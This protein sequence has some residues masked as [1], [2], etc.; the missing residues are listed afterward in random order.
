VDVRCR[1]LVNK[2]CS[3][4]PNGSTTGSQAIRGYISVMVRLKFNVWL[5]LIA[6]L[7]K[8]AVCLFRPSVRI[9][10]SLNPCTQRER[11]QLN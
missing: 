9:P 7:I 8:L 3:A 4:D 11:H 10:I 6:E 1:P 2:M 5:K